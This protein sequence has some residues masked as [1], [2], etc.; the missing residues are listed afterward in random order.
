MKFDPLGDSVEI[1][2]SDSD[3][4]LTPNGSV[5]RALAA[6][7]LATLL[8]RMLTL[9]VVPV[10]YSY[11]DDLAAWA[12]RRLRAQPS[13]GGSIPAEMPAAKE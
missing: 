3:G 13:A 5:D 6:L 12:R 7:A 9:I 10:I 2:L 8:L 1:E 4:V 11:M